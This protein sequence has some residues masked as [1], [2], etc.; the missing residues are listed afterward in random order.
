MRRRTPNIE[1]IRRLIGFEPEFDLDR[2]LADVIA[3]IGSHLNDGVE[4]AV[5][6]TAVQTA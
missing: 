4:D 5:S 3:D 6:S 2:I 1:K